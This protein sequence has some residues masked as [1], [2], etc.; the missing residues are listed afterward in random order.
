[1]QITHASLADA[2]RRFSANRRSAKPVRFACCVE[3]PTGRDR[4]IEEHEALDAAA[5]ILEAVHADPGLALHL[6][7][8]VAQHRRS[9]L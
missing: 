2:L 9:R 8:V 3:S 1:M 4:F 5:E 6:D 7:A